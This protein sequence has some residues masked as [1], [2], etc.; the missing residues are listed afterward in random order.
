MVLDFFLK[1]VLLKTASER[2]ASE[3]QLKKLGSF[4]IKYK[5]ANKKSLLQMS[6]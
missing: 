6:F 1:V 2:E 3:R 5:M 4:R